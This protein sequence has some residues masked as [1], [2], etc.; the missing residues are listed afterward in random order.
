MTMNEAYTYP[1]PVPIENNRE[2]VEKDINRYIKRNT[3]RKGER[4]GIPPLQSDLLDYTI[5]FMWRVTLETC[6]LFQDD[7]N[8]MTFDEVLKAL[9]DG[10]IGLF[11]KRVRELQDLGITIECVGD[12]DGRESEGTGKTE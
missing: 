9:N 8:R 6:L 12:N 5:E 3:P 7:E 4:K 1:A 10:T 2:Q 11:L